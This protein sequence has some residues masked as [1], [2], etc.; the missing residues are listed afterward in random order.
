MAFFSLTFL[1]SQFV[2]LKALR[3]DGNAKCRHLKLF[4]CEGDIA[5]GVYLS[6]AQNPIHPPP[7][8]TMYTCV[9]YIYSHMEGGGG[10]GERRLEG[11]QVTKLG[12]KYKHDWLYLQSI[13]S[14]KRLPQRSLL[15]QFFWMTKLKFCFGVYK[16]YY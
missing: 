16:V 11:Q 3:I 13:N 1:S 9:Q 6:E 8:C 2:L 5:A 4:T 12:Q 14:D 15:G 7:P 10:G